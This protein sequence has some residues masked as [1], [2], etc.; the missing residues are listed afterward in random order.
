[1]SEGPAENRGEVLKTALDPRRLE[2][3]AIIRIGL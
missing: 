3:T 1:V 2:L